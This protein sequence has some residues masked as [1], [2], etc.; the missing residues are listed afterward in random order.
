MAIIGAG[1]VGA[2]IAFATLMRGA[3]RHV[4]LYDIDAQKVAAEALDLSHGI[5]FPPMATIEGSDDIKVC[6][7][8]DLVVGRRGALEKQVPPMTGA[9]L[10]GLRASADH[11]RRVAVPLGL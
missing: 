10:A 8:A 11:I 6:R 3:A 2:T 5:R 7:D 9:E 1:A 4:A